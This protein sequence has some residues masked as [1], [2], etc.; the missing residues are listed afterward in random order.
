M[1]FTLRQ[2]QEEQ[3]PWVLRNFGD[4]PAWMPL[5]GICEEL[6]ELVSACTPCASRQT[7][8]WD[9]LRDA[10]GD[11]VIFAADYCTAMGWDL[12]E[13]WDERDRAEMDHD[14]RVRHMLLCVSRLQ[15][16]YLKA[17]QGIR[18]TSSQH[19]VM[20]Q[21][22]MSALLWEL[23]RVAGDAEFLAAVEKTWSRVKLRDWKKDA[24]TGG[25]AA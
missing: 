24:I 4:R 18:G 6:G 7:T 17:A 25:D 14:E 19:S 2:L 16:H 11:T 1:T 3:K 10:I 23:A 8:D 20:G 5:M 22:W 21:A 13:L 9:A 15:H 12:Q